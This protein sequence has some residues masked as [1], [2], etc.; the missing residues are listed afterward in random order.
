MLSDSERLLQL[1]IEGHRTV[2][3]MIDLMSF[4]LQLGH[5]QV[6]SGAARHTAGALAAASGYKVM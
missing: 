6:R 5:V 4:V 2:T 3:I 1:E